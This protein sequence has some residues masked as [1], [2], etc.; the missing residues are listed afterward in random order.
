MICYFSKYIIKFITIII[1]QLFGS[2]HRIQTFII[3]MYLTFDDGT[4]IGT[5]FFLDIFKAEEIRATFFIRINLFDP[6]QN[7]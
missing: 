4:N 5:N 3:S 7:F 2:I 6:T 1:L